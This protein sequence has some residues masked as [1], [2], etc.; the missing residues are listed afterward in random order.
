MKT[1]MIRV[2]GCSAERSQGQDEGGYY[3]IVE[4]PALDPTLEKRMQR[5]MG[6]RNDFYNHRQNCGG[7][8]CWSLPRDANFKGPGKPTCWM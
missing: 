7:N 6:C 2:Y 4:A 8:T 5:C 3:Q 1:R